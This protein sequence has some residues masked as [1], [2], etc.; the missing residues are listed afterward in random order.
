MQWLVLSLNEGSHVVVG[1]S[2]LGC[3]PR[4]RPLSLGMDNMFD[5]ALLL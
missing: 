2:G 3:E 4:L 5:I 1:A